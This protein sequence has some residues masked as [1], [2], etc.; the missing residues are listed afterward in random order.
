MNRRQSSVN[1]IDIFQQVMSVF[2]GKI[3]IL[4]IDLLQGWIASLRLQ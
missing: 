2:S 3:I 4:S 1:K